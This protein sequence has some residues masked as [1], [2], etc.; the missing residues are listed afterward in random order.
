MSSFICALESGDTET[1]A[2]KDST[3]SSTDDVTTTKKAF[4]SRLDAVDNPE[5]YGQSQSVQL[6][7]TNPSISH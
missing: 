3:Q 1:S 2:L 5:Y 7:D 4:L 6:L